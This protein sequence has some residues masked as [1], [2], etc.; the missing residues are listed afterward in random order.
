MTPSELK[1]A[2]QDLP[3][4]PAHPKRFSWPRRQKEI[5]RH[6]ERDG[7]DDMLKWSTMIETMFVGNAPYIPLEYEW[8]DARYLDVISE[9]KVGN[10][11]LY[12]GWTSGNL[13]HQAYHL[14]QW[15][16]K[17]GKRV[18]ELD[19]IV[20]IGGGYGAMCL[21]CRR[22]GFEGWYHIIDLPEFS[23]LQEYYLSNI[24]NV[25]KTT[26]CNNGAFPYHATSNLCIGLWSVSEV[27]NKVDRK[28][29]LRFSEFYKSFL[30]AYA[31]MWDGVNNMEWFANFADTRPDLYWCDWKIEHLPNSR[32]RV[33]V[34]K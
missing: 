1:Q 21:I 20:E 16:Q 17:S 29:L 2:I 9:P 14:M 31:P 25:D 4:L 30:F 27:P 7:V 33:G 15:E 12:E 24:I 5:R 10:P 13:I 6:I 23:L 28:S 19:S 18:E 22:L 11:E 32:Y 26:F 3:P 34:T 8:L